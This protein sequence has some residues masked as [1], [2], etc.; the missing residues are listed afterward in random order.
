MTRRLSFREIIHS[1]LSDSLRLRLALK[2][3][4]AC[5]I[6]EMAVLALHLSQGYWVIITIFVVMQFTVST[7]TKKALMRI[8]GTAAGCIVGLILV[9][10]IPERHSLILGVLSVW[11]MVLL[12]FSLRG[13]YP[14]ACLLAAL[15]PM[16]I[17]FTGSGHMPGAASLALSRFTDIAVGSTIAWL[18]TIFVMPVSE[19]KEIKLNSGRL[20]KDVLAFALTVAEGSSIETVMERK[21]RKTLKRQ[22]FLC[23]AIDSSMAPYLGI[24]RY[25]SILSV[26]SFLFIHVNHVITILIQTGSGR[27]YDLSRAS[28]FLAEIR[29][30]MMRLKAIPDEHVLS[31]LADNRAYIGSLHDLL[32]SSFSVILATKP[33]E[34]EMNYRLKILFHILDF[35]SEISAIGGDMDRP[36]DE[37]AGKEKPLCL[38]PGKRLDPDS[39]LQAL[40]STLA[41]TIAALLWV[42]PFHSPQA[43]ISAL[44]VSLSGHQSPSYRKMFFRVLGTVL[45][46]AAGLAIMIVMV[47]L[48]WIVFIMLPLLLFMFSYIG[49]GDEE[50]SYSG[51]TSGICFVLCINLALMHQDSMTAVLNRVEG[52]VLGGIIAAAVTRFLFPT[53]YQGKMK[54]LETEL[55]AFQGTCIEVC[56]ACL[57]GTS[58]DEEEFLALK[59]RLRELTKRYRELVMD[60][61]LD[62]MPPAPA[63]QHHCERTEIML[64]IYRDI[65]S[66]FYSL[67]HMTLPPPRRDR[68]PLGEL[69]RESRKLFPGMEGNPQS[70]FDDVTFSEALSRV[71]EALSEI[72][73]A[74]CNDGNAGLSWE[75]VLYL[76]VI[77]HD[78]NILRELCRRSQ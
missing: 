37:K 60:Y 26:G 17:A 11:C 71:R 21:L 15:T 44:L 24:R 40:K 3:A 38:L 7:T 41:V 66:L 53:D 19:M 1:E 64:D 62:R 56:G 61:L 51:V 59:T 57:E 29:Q 30:F 9:T 47:Y 35:L 69:M 23:A 6:G 58:A 13:V 67:R 76:D 16:V 27:E 20:I 8:V 75:S 25:C 43:G 55:S 28:Q 31:F 45:G 49:F 2:T 78:L 50:W 65:V 5:I 63:R 73:G 74:T 54:I 36:G 33:E 12:Y 4:I 22:E 68:E 70:E 77:L 18:V 72:R 42:V 52:V 34:R 39:A 48:H 14:Y 10:L 32:S 46:G